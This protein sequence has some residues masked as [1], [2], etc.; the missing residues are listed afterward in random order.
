MK[1]L[2]G[3]EITAATADNFFFEI[4]AEFL[5]NTKKEIVFTLHTC[6]VAYSNRV[7]LMGFVKPYKHTY[8]GAR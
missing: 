6:M 8:P 7:T 5:C 4:R 2:G 1:V 3:N